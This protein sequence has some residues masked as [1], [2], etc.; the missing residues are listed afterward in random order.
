MNISPSTPIQ[1]VDQLK[2]YLQVALQ[3]EHATIPP[4]LTAAY[5]ARIEANKS[6]T[7][8]IKAVAKEEMLHLT[9]AANL[10]NAVGGSPDLKEHDFVP[11]YPTFLPTGQDDFDVG[12]A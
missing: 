2:K 9:L 4:Y 8:V 11:S 10:L 7:D 3:L 12:I 6:S 5:S 1:N